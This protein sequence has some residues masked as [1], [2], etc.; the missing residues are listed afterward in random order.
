MLRLNFRV[1]LSLS[2][3]IEVIVSRARNFRGLS[4]CSLRGRVKCQP[5]RLHIPPI[6][7]TFITIHV[8]LHWCFYYTLYVCTY[9]RNH[10]IVKARSN[11]QVLYHDINFYSALRYS[12]FMQVKSGDSSTCSFSRSYLLSQRRRCPGNRLSRIQSS[13]SKAQVSSKIW[14]A[15]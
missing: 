7:G 8:G 1:S 10:E 9:R 12:F 13:F 6:V 2:K 11:D 4:S 15:S 14:S 5:N 3:R